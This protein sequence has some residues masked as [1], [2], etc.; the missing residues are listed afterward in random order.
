MAARPRAAAAAL[1]RARRRRTVTA[2]AETPS[3]PVAA[4]RRVP[5]R[6]RRVSATGGRGPSTAPA[7]AWRHHAGRQPDGPARTAPGA[8]AV[9]RP[10]GRQRHG[11]APPPYVRDVANPRGRSH[12]Q[13]GED[14]EQLRLCQHLR[15]GVPDRDRQNPGSGGL[16]HHRNPY[17]DRA[18]PP[19]GHWL[20]RG[21]RPAR[22][23]PRHLLLGRVTGQREQH[24]V[25]EVSQVNDRIP[26][27]HRLACRR[28]RTVQV[29]AGI[30]AQDSERVVVA[31]FTHRGSAPERVHR[32]VRS[33]ARSAYRA[34]HGQRPGWHR[35]PSARISGLRDELDPAFRPDPSCTARGMGARRAIQDGIDTA[36]AR[37]LQR[38]AG[39]SKPVSPLPVASHASRTANPEGEVRRQT[40]A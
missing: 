40:A 36:P 10:S 29:T 18:V 8:A 38:S 3:T 23:R 26:G 14:A 35:Y 37:S 11:P 27:R 19:A 39:Y 30:M 16:F 21:E 28:E 32:S 1:T 6:P 25:G 22:H 34:P 17:P 9:P 2:A 15:I 5:A 20:A 33:A 7:A 31:G 13:A 24:L 12:D 4:A